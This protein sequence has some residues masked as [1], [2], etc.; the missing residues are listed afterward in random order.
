MIFNNFLLLASA[1]NEEKL[2]KKEIKMT[3]LVIIFCVNSILGNFPNKSANLMLYFLDPFSY[4]L[5]LA[6][7]NGLI[8]F[9]HG[10]KFLINLFFNDDFYQTFL[11]MICRRKNRV[12]NSNNSSQIN[13]DKNTQKTASMTL[14]LETAG[15]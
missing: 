6:I 2:S 8:W 10:N 15:T 3:I 1:T 7:T 14:N 11:I 5:Y 9:S 12:R 4:N 13:S